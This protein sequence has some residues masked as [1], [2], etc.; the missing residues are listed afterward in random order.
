MG[1]K[2]CDSD[3]EEDDEE[4]GGSCRKKGARKITIQVKVMGTPREFFE[5]VARVMGPY[6]NHLWRKRHQEKVINLMQGE[7][8]RDNELFLQADFAMKYSHNH[9]DALQSE[10]F[11][12]WLS[13]ILMIIVCLRE[14]GVVKYHMHVVLSCDK[15]QSNLFV[16]KAFELVISYYQGTNPIKVY[17]RPLHDLQR[18]RIAS[19]GCRGQ[20]KCKGEIEA[21]CSMPEVLRNLVGR[22]LRL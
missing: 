8:L 22:Q 19:D 4:A 2:D 17:E 15:K 6:F 13:T 12:V 18:V 21:C 20:F 16:Q 5:Y 9:R 11:L 14:D 1:G 10:W 7:A 3:L